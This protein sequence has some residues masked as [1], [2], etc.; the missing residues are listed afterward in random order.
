M[1]PV[2]PAIRNWSRNSD[3]EEHRRLEL[4]LSTP[5]RAE[6]I[7]DLDAGRDRDSHCRKHKKLLA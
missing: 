6:P 7:E 4:D 5:H 2:S 3:A 1:T